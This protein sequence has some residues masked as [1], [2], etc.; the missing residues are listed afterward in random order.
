[1]ITDQL[2]GVSLNKRFRE[3]MNEPEDLLSVH[4]ETTTPQWLSQAFKE[5]AKEVSRLPAWIAL[6]G[7]PAIVV[8]H[9]KLSPEQMK[10]VL[11]A[12]QQSTLSE[13]H[14]LIEALTTNLS[15]NDLNRFTWTLLKD[16][17]EKVPIQKKSGL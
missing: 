7:I 3:V 16:G 17:Y 1:M 10:L 9:R 15:R 13:P 4:D 8:E 14:K 11:T 12:C 2:V 6:A 5:M